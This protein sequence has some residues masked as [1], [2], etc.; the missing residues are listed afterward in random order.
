[1]DSERAHATGTNS[2]TFYTRSSSR[3]L[4]SLRV[5]DAEGSDQLPLT[6]VTAV[7]RAACRSCAAGKS[8]RSGLMVSV[9]VRPAA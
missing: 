2:T 7:M 5:A 8:L 4:R 9:R 1:M 6:G 3:S